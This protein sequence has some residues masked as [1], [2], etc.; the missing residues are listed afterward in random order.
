MHEHSH[1]FLKRLLE[2]PSPSGYERP[3]QDVVRHWAADF[4]DE[5][6]TDRHGNVLAVRHG[7]AGRDAEPRVMLAGHCD[8]IGLMAQY[9]DDNGYLYV[10]PIGGWDMQILLGQ[11]LTVWTR[12]GPVHGV[13]ARRATHLLTNEERNKVPLFTDVWV[14][15][16]FKDRK[17]AEQV[18]SAGDPVTFA[19]GYRPLRNGL[20][21][22]PAMDDKVGLWTVMETLRLLHGKPLQCSVY[23]VSTVQEEIGLRGATTSAYGIHPTVGVAVDV[24]HATDTPGNDKKQLGDTKVGAGPVL[25][26]GP[27]IN[28]RVLEG[29]QQAA[30][31]QDIPV[32]VRGT[33][34]A[35]GTD[36]NAIQLSREGVAAGLVGIPNRYMHSPVEVVS[37]EDLDRA[38]RVLA[39][40]CLGVTSQ[41][42]WTP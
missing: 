30:K 15:C 12:E 42:D 2:T 38:A 23:C 4:A 40:F 37:L 31:A 27:N 20:A 11:D 26:R 32:Q 17:E 1:D 21:A 16:G 41:T 18:V 13:I 3:I 5:V 7:L 25:F 28:P 39:A 33:P 22:S 14:D 35:T 34:R 8:Q 19:L 36:A 10:Q 29:L 9:V 24:C 6:R